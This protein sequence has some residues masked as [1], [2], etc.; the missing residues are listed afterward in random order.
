M[1]GRIV[2]NVGVVSAGQF[3]IGS[4][5]IFLPRRPSNSEDLVERRQDYI[6][7]EVLPKEGIF[8]QTSRLDGALLRVIRFQV[9]CP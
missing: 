9:R 8:A 5:Q 1:C 3:P 2:T 4:A 6:M 7:N